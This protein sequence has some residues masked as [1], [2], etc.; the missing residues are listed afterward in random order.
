MSPHQDIATSFDNSE[1]KR[2]RLQAREKKLSRAIQ[3]EDM[4]VLHQRIRLLNKQ[5]EELKSQAGL[6][7]HRLQDSTFRWS[8]LGEQMRALMDWIDDMEMKIV[9]SREVHVEDLLNKLETVSSK[10]KMPVTCLF[11]LSLPRI[12]D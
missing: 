11:T 10:R 4:N 5:W 8:N 6:R 1:D 3:A 2:Q 12:H 7:E 9:S